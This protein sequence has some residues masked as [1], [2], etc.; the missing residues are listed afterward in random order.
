MDIC[1]GSGSSSGSRSGLRSGSIIG[2]SGFSSFCGFFFGSK[3]LANEAAL[4]LL[5]WAFS[6][7]F[8]TFLA[9]LSSIFFWAKASTSTL[10]FFLAASAAA[11]F[12]SLASAFFFPLTSFLALALVSLLSKIQDGSIFK[13]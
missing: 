13:L 10:F 1:S 4:R 7:A 9:A 5:I 8:S 11:L 3:L 12:F 2:F 6:S